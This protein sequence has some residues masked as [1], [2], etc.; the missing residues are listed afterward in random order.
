MV[1]AQLEADG[2]TLVD[3]VLSEPERQQILARLAAT[4]ALPQR[5]A[6]SRDLLHQPWCR[7]LAENLPRHPA[8]APLLAGLRAVQCTLFDKS[9]ARNWLVGWHQDLSLPV[10][11]LS[12]TRSWRGHAIKQGQRFAQPPAEILESTLA[13]RIHLDANTAGNGAL[14][15]LP[16]SH[17]HGRLDADRIRSLRRQT[18]EIACLAAAGSALLMRP[19]LLHASSRASDDTPRRT[20]HFVFTASPAAR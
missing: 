18:A 3:G 9:A 14:R 10:D 13:I 5:R 20:L 2:C 12:D 19:L 7:H 11:A 16:G 8:L 1:L 15:L 17:R 6:G 4:T